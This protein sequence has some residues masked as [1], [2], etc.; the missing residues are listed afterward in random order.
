VYSSLRLLDIWYG[1][2]QPEWAREK[3]S[4]PKGEGMCAAASDTWR[5]EA[6]T[7]M[8]SCRAHQRQPVLQV[9]VRLGM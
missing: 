2:A 4:E 1:H 6:Q 8:Q 5:G 9:R 7:G 3:G